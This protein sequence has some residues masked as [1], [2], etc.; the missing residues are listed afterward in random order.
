MREEFCGSVPGP[1]RALHPISN[2]AIGRKAHAA[3]HLHQP[4]CVHQETTV[5]DMAHQGWSD[6][7][8]A[9]CLTRPYCPKVSARS[10][11]GVHRWRQRV[12]RFGRMHSTMCR[13]IEISYPAVPKWRN[14]TEYRGHQPYPTRRDIEPVA[15]ECSVRGCPLSRAIAAHP[16]VTQ[17]SG[18]LSR[19]KQST[20]SLK[21]G[22]VS[23]RR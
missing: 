14:E 17:M 11:C 18:E 12:A 15:W 7:H 9:P 16:I 22:V 21:S 4:S 3:L 8:R 5:V 2:P 1:P 23:L 10:L 6:L 13:E 20:C 19:L